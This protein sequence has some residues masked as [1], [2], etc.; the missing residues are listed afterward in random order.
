MRVF[1]LAVFLKF[2]GLLF[3]F[4]HVIASDVII[5]PLGPVKY[6]KTLGDHLRLSYS[7]IITNNLSA[8]VATSGMFLNEL[9]LVEPT[10]IA[11]F[12][13]QET[14]CPFGDISQYLKPKGQVG[15]SCYVEYKTLIPEVAGNFLNQ[16]NVSDAFGGNTLSSVFGVSVF[17]KGKLGHFVFEENGDPV[18]ALSLAPNDNGVVV[19]KNTGGMT[20]TDVAVSNLTHTG[21]TN[22]D[23]LSSNGILMPKGS[24][25]FSY[26][27]SSIPSTKSFIVSV[28][29][30]NVDN[31]PTLDVAVAPRVYITNNYNS[32]YYVSVCNVDKDTGALSHCKD[33][34]LTELNQPY[35]ITFNHTDTRA[36]IA[37]FWVDKIWQCDI[38]PVTGLFSH[39]K[40]S[41][42][43]GFY[44]PRYLAIT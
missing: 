34:G 19:L 42:G 31:V 36:Y 4:N 39:C 23:C 30:I 24:C 2:F 28:S 29:G 9:K 8:A 22:I 35:G 1:S 10:G 26:H 3:L 33:S 32:R 15:D 41:K 40:D 38:N 43:A 44:G 21:F 37:N 5:K 27:I 16:F 20:I 13:L 6:Q 18:S 7:F 17:P 25:H 14:N 11:E 12:K